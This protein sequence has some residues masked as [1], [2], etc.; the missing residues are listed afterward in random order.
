MEGYY[1]EKCN[2]F[3]LTTMGEFIHPHT[4]K[5]SCLVCCK[6]GGMVY[7]RKREEAYA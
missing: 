3:V 2:K 7:I 1:C 4:G 5:Q 6:C